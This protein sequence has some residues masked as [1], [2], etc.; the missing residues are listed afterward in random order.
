VA[1]RDEVIDQ[2]EILNVV[3]GCQGTE[4][5][6]VQ[7]GGVFKEAAHFHKRLWLHPN[8]GG[9]ELGCGVWGMFVNPSRDILSRKY[10]GHI[11]PS[12]YLLS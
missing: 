7:I 1:H 9:V 11:S 5:G 6:E 10:P 8:V 4:E 3:D 2:L 12:A